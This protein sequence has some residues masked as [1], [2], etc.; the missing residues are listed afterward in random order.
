MVLEETT[1]HNGTI[2]D[3]AWAYEHLIDPQLFG[4]ISA[5]PAHAKFL[6][7]LCFI[8]WRQIHLLFA[9][10]RTMYRLRA[11]QPAVVIKVLQRP[12]ASDR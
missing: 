6:K 5:M 1:C 10:L 4:H 2:D 3:R 12:P 7:P 9:A 8:D 11:L